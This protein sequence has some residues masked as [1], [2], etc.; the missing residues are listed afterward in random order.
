MFICWSTPG[1]ILMFY[2]PP[3]HVFPNVC[4]GLW[5]GWEGTFKDFDESNQNTST[6]DDRKTGRGCYPHHENPRDF[7]EILAQPLQPTHCCHLWGATA[8]IFGHCCHLGGASPAIWPHP[9]Y[10]SIFNFTIF[11]SSNWY[12][13]F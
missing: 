7:A 10:F 3:F 2:H 9:K 6:R 11:L 1:C 12:N 8:A 13:V 5:C 4:S